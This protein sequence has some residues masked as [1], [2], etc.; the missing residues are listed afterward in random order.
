MKLPLG[1]TQ[2]A[3]GIVAQLLH[4]LVVAGITAQ[5]IWAWRIDEADSIRAEFA[6]VNQH[7]SIGM[8]ILGLVVLRL[9]WR[10]FNRPP[11]FPTSMSTW[12]KFAA[13]TAHWLLYAL[14]LAMPLSGWIYTSAAG[15][16]AEFFGLV[17]IPDLVDRGER[18]EAVF[19]EVHEWLAIGILALVS[20]HVLAALR[21]QWLLKDGLL[22]RM[23]P[24]WK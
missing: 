4:W 11:P 23:L 14:I 9:L 1:N 13:S 2:T 22:K 3:Y 24:I 15:F 20:I 12:E 19:G 18:L 21:H 7:K 10:A 17:D 8:T 5:F 6:L 16:G